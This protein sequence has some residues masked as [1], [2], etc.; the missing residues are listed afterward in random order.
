VL[1]RRLDTNSVAHEWP[2]SRQRPGNYLVWTWAAQCRV[3]SST[4]TASEECVAEAAERSRSRRLRSTRR[5][6][7]RAQGRSTRIRSGTSRSRTFRRTTT[8]ASGW[9]LLRR[10]RVDCGQQGAGECPCSCAVYGRP[11]WPLVRRP[12]RWR[13]LPVA[14]RSQ[15]GVRAIGRLLR[16]LQCNERWQRRLGGEYPPFLVTPCPVD[17]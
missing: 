10:L 4:L 3:T 5:A 11:E 1:D 12:G 9:D 8:T 17:D 6:H 7:T 13:D 15:P 16:Q 2:T 14:A